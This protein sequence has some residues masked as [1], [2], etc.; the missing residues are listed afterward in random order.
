MDL[1]RVLRL[2]EILWNLVQ[3]LSIPRKYDAWSSIVSVMGCSSFSVTLRWKFNLWLNNLGL[4][5]GINPTDL[6]T[7]D[8]SSSI[9]LS[10]FLR[11]CRS[12]SGCVI[13]SLQL[14]Q[15]I[16]FTALRSNLPNVLCTWELLGTALL[17][18][19]LNDLNI[20][21]RTNM[22]L[23][24]ISNPKSAKWHLFQEFLVMY[25]V[26]ILQTQMTNGLHPY[27]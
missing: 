1:F 3:V 23:M 22:V 12:T 8:W 14:S 25:C 24:C 4:L 10:V 7:S 27:F 5:K 9:A 21:S 18:I 2:S 19:F 20:P 16:W 13:D 11:F 15:E 17:L 6:Q 26:W